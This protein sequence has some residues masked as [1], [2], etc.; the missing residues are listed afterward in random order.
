MI[1]S[2]IS[3]KPN[4][5]PLDRPLLIQLVLSVLFSFILI[6]AAGVFVIAGIYQFYSQGSA[7]QNVTQ[8]FMLA[9]SLAFAGALVI[10]SAWYAWKHIAYPHAQRAEKPEPRRFG[11]I[12]TL[13]TLI[14]SGLALIIGNL[15]AQN[16]QIAWLILPPL[17]IIATG[18]PAIWV[19]YFGTRGLLPN[20]PRYKWGVFASGL[21]LGPL[22]ILIIELAMLIGVGI[23]AIVWIMLDPT[24]APQF[25]GFLH[26]LQ[27]MGTNPQAIL[28]NLPT[29]LL[30]PGVLFIGFAFVAVLVPIV[31]ETFKP[32]GVWFM[33][34]RKITPA[35]GFGFGV[36]S[37]A[38]FGL[39]EN[40]GNT[41]AGGESWALLAGSRISTLLLH[42]FTAGLVGWALAYAWSERR[43]LRLAVCF[44]IAILIHGLWN[45]MA[46]LS[47]ASSLEGLVPI[48]L[49]TWLQTLATIATP[50]IFVLGLA[51]VIG[52]FLFN[53]SLRQNLAT[54]PLPAA[55]NVNNAYPEAA[56]PSPETSLPAST[57][58][59]PLTPPLQ[60]AV[61]KPSSTVHELPLQTSPEIP[62]KKSETKP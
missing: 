60:A 37:G 4:K 14:G 26:Q 7:G 11:L 20:I 2:G 3:N 1:A 49:P 34:G 25:S 9:G 16:D 17:N 24:L 10:P 8:S 33:A 54:A 59:G 62:P 61:D 58:G 46:I 15:V 43:F 19:I 57:P 6:A 45:G 30:N 27:T 48:S 22:I 36:L 39:F 35:Q 32:I 5:A 13:I 28:N 53:A 18:L 31:E 38:G 47:T 55:E 56:L 50:G 44:G 23:L 29:F 52:F 40:L 42:S 12:L 21:V 41:S 51:V